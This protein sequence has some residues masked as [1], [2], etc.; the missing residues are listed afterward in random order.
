MK[1]TISF[2]L[3]KLCNELNR[4]ILLDL[5]KYPI[6]EYLIKEEL[7]YISY[8]RNVNRVGRVNVGIALLRGKFGPSY[9]DLL[10]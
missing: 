10:D 7:S 5:V 6:A 8:I 4:F 9:L 1:N 3:G 2:F